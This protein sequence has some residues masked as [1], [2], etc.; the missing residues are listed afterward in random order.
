VDCSCTALEDLRQWLKTEGI[1]QVVMESTGP[2]GCRLFNVLE[3]DV[4]V[5]LA[6]P[7]EVKNRKGHKTDDQDS[8]WFGASAT[9]RNDPPS[10]IPEK[11][12]VGTCGN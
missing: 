10:F 12:T 11:A 4:K 7:V 6:N 9:A 1:T 2:T 5:V 3:T 8:W